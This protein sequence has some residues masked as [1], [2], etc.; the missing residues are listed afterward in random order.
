MNQ[1][2]SQEM[3]AGLEETRAEMGRTIDEIQTRV[4]PSGIIDQVLWQLRSGGGRTVADGASEFTS[5]LVRTLRE[6]PVPSLLIGTGLAW[7]AVTSMRGQRRSGHEKG[8]IDQEVRRRAPRTT[9][10]VEAVRAADPHAPFGRQNVGAAPAGRPAHTPQQARADSETAVER[11]RRA[12]EAAR[13]R[14]GRATGTTGEASEAAS[15]SGSDLHRMSTLE[16]V[17]AADPHA[18]FSPH[19]LGAKRAKQ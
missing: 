18:P 10:T 15:T 6:N 8:P 5:N 17:R 12:A 13:E 7:L 4:S 1:R 11:A 14:A 3:Q 19:S 16:A 9:P 2:S